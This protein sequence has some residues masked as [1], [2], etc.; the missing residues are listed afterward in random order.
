MIIIL[1]RDGQLCNQLLTLSSAYVLSL[2]YKEWVICPVIDKKIQDD[3]P[4]LRTKRCGINSKIQ[5]Y[6]SNIC[7]LVMLAGKFIKKINPQISKKKYFITSSHRLYFFWDWI[8]FM[9]EK[10]YV[11]Y[12]PEIRQLFSVRQDIA[13]KYNPLFVKEK[14][15]YCTVGVH[16]R[17]GDYRSFNDG[18]WFYTDKQYADWMKKLTKSKEDVKFFLFSN[19]KVNLEYYLSNGL[20][21]VALNGNAVE[22]LYCLS[23]CDYIMGPPSTYSWWA[24]M[25]GNKKRLILEDGKC[26]CTWEDFLYLEDRVNTGTNLH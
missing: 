5:F 14:C 19:E 3:F 18:K 13:E 25:Y 23:Q 1:A 2:K 26:S 20:N 7:E 24:A 12:Q 9:D 11:Y 17:R 10:A 22:D 6:H 16:M 15:K 4:Y 8:S 21:V